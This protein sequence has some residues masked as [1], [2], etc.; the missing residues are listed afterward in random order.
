M[1]LRRCVCR[2]LSVEMETCTSDCAESMAA[3]V[4]RV[5]AI[6]MRS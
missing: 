1:V 3:R 4:T 5:V 2:V 6:D